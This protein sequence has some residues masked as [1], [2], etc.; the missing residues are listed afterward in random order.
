MLPLGILRY[1]QVPSAF[2]FAAKPRQRRTRLAVGSP[3]AAPLLLELDEAPLLELDEV[4]STAA[5]LAPACEVESLPMP[6]WLKPST[7]T[8]NSCVRA[9]ES[10]KL[11][12]SG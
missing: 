6:I 3:A 4:P 5:Q 8:W 11:W 2:G 9:T 7:P 1:G 12:S 10:E